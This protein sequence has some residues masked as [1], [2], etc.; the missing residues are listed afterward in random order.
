MGRKTDKEY[1]ERAIEISKEALETGNDGFGCLLVDED[2]E[3]VMEQRNAVADEGDP[4]AHDAMT[5]LRKAV[6][7]YDAG[8]LGKCTLY[9]TMEPCVMCMGAAFWA[10]L[11]AVKFAVTEKE[12]G[13]ILSG[14]L[15]MPSTEFAERSPKPIRVEGPFMEVHDEAFAV[16]RAW[17]DKILGNE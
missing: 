14:G 2:G 6:K 16:M 9:A 7:K 10:G 12:L 3:I 8:Y 4:T 15:D 11:G 13:T 17:V 5:L 1:F